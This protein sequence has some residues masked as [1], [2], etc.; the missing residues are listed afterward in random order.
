[1]RTCFGGSRHVDGPAGRTG[2]RAANAVGGSAPGR[3]GLGRGSGLP[4]GDHFAPGHVTSEHIAS[5]Y[6]AAAHLVS[7]CVTAECAIDTAD[8]TAPV[9]AVVLAPVPAALERHQPL[10]DTDQL[11][12]LEG[13]GE[14]GVDTDIEAGLDL[15][16]RARA[17]DGDGKITGE[18]IG[19]QPLGRTDTVEPGHDD[20]EGDDVGPHLVDDFKTLG[21]I[22][23]GHHLEAL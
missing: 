4:G 20:V 12:G 6:L 17:H 3:F 1:M 8:T 11:G 23:R 15:E 18:R 5:P 19:P 9:T 2:R 14:E 21:T 22:G 16:L 13:L 10:Y 7:G